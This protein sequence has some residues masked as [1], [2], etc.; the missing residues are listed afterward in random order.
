MRRVWWPVVSAIAIAGWLLLPGQ[1]R[2]EAKCPWLNAATASG[3]LGGDV[4]MTVTPPREPAAQS[5]D[6]T[7]Y[8]ADQVRMDRFDVSCE[9][10]RAADSGLN[11]LDIAVTTMSDP[12]KEFPSF[13]S[14][15]RGTT[16]ALKAI[17]NDAVQCVMKD[18]GTNSSNRVEQVIARVRNRAFVLTVSRHA[19]AS[20]AA[21]GDELSPDTRNIAEQV[22][23]SLF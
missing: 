5:P 9:F 14:L 7:V 3:I 20:A 11:T 12:A 16:V 22:A 23:G 13:L 2:A 1:C 6:P 18:G 21:V 19:P 17:G 15:C 4:R 8:Q 10:Q